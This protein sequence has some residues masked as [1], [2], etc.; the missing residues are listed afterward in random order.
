MVYCM[1]CGG[2]FIDMDARLVHPLGRHT[3]YFYY[4]MGL[5]QVALVPYDTK[6]H[7]MR[8][9]IAAAP[10]PLPLRARP[11]PPRLRHRLPRLTAPHV[12]KLRFS[13]RLAT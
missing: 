4:S 1:C 10:S 8:D 7:D 3:S 9:A 12:V 13:R 5:C 2:F 6:H 11:R